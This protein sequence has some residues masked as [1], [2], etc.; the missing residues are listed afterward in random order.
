MKVYVLN[1]NSGFLMVCRVALEARG[2]VVETSCDDTMIRAD[3]PRF[4]PDVIVLDWRLQYRTGGQVLQELQAYFSELPPVLVISSL[5]S[6]EAEEV[7]LTQ[8]LRDRE[9]RSIR[10]GIGAGAQVTDALPEQQSPGQASEHFAAAVD[11]EMTGELYG[12]F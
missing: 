12:E 1:D 7:L 6:I 9:S 5:E 11:E 4:Q 8:R 3:V 10:L 2:H